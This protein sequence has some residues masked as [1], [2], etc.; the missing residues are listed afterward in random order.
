M[1]QD[2]SKETNEAITLKMLAEYEQAQ[3]IGQHSDAVF[4]E[5]AAIAWG[6]NTLLLGFILE[7]SC[8]SS[9]QWLVIVAAVIGLFISG[10]VPFVQHL[11][12]I[13]Q[14]IA[15]SV[16]R[17]IEEELELPHRLN[18]Q[19]HKEYPPKRGQ[20][21]VW[22]ITVVFVLAWLCVI[23]NATYCLQCRSTS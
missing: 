21:A 17:E 5:V 22:V 1:K 7:V 3:S 15:Y 4:H 14:P 13:G 18:N 11:I 9:N 2:A 19:I 8:G 20:R 10:Y 6:A 12:K 16:C 23:V